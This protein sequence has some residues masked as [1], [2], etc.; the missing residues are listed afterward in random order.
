MIDR[1]MLFG[2]GLNHTSAN[3]F[4][5]SPTLAPGLHRFCPLWVFHMF[6]HR[7]DVNR[8]ALSLCRDGAFLRANSHDGRL[9]TTQDVPPPAQANASSSPTARGTPAS[10]ATSP[11][12]SPGST[13]SPFH[14]EYP[15]TRLGNNVRKHHG[16][17]AAALMQLM[18]EKWRQALAEPC[19]RGILRGVAGTAQE[20]AQAESRL[21][22]ARNEETLKTITDLLH[23][24][25][26]NNALQTSEDTKHYIRF[27]EPTVELT[28]AIEMHFGQ[29]R[30]LDAEL[31]VVQ[32]P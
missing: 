28:K 10:A 7:G 21:L 5:F 11:R 29:G 17:V 15:K 16:K 20:L 27:L 22:V 14:F 2:Q 1:R 12:A 19:L 8:S 31:L 32:A 26:A 6:G 30:R 23:L 25:G 4:F 24:C 18:G 9:E 13:T 3:L